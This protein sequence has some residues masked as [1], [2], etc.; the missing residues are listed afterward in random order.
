MPRADTLGF[1]ASKWIWTATTASNAVRALRKDFTPPFGKSL[2]AADVIIAADNS[3]TL[4]V[5]CDLIGSAE[6]TRFAR[7]FCVSLLP[8]YNVF[9]V[10]ASTSAAANGALIATILVT[11][12]DGTTDTIVSDSSW[13]V[14]NSVPA[15]FEQLSFDDTA[16]VA[17]T[18][19]GNYGASPWT[20]VFIPADPPVVSIT[21]ANWIWTDVAPAS[22]I[23]YPAGQ[24]V[25][26]KTFIPAAGEIPISATILITIDNAYTLYVNGVRV[27]S[28]SNWKVGQHYTVNLLPT[29]ELVFAVV[30]T[31][32]VLSA[33]GLIASIEINMAAAGRVNCSAGALVISNASWKS[34]KGAIPTG[35]EL[36]GFDDSAWPAVKVE[37]AY[38]GSPW[39]PVTFAAP[40]PPVTA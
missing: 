11:Y 1:S 19:V 24:R 21:G 4:F 22:G 39:G 29:P 30:A 25:F 3:L 10:N 35:W 17:A 20:T 12:S 34:P 27:G 16:W 36:P 32:T 38:T 8:S 33:A 6:G 31:N 40:S 9:A 18:T 15:G 23:E 14:S 13:R 26:R 2:I 37:S 28:G 7:R 5:N